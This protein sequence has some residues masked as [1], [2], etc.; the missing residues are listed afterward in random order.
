MAWTFPQVASGTYLALHR[1]EHWHCR[2]NLSSQ[3]VY[4]CHCSVCWNRLC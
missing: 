3:I 1:I 4:S 2:E